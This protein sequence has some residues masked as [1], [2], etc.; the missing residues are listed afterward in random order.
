MAIFFCAFLADLC[1][2]KTTVLRWFMG[3]H[4]L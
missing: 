2:E 1:V 3:L 4:T